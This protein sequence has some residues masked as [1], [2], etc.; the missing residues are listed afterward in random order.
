MRPIKLTLSAFG[1]YAGKEVL[2]LSELGE[3]GLYLVTGKTGAG[4]TSLFDAIAYALYDKPSGDVRDDSMLR[5]TYADDSTE[6]FVEL[7][8]L[9][10]E[11]LYRVRRNPEY[12]RLKARGEGKTKQSARAELIL[13]DGRVIDKSKKEVTRAITEIIGIDREQFLQIAMI[14]QGEF[15]KVLLAD[16]EER[17][18]I[19]RQ[20][21][22][23]ERY[24]TLQN[25]L[26]E[27]TLALKRE[28]D[29]VR[30]T[31]Y[32][33]ARNVRYAEDGK[34]VEQA[35]KAKFGELTV[36]ETTELLQNLIA[37]DEAKNAAVAQS[38][39]VAEKRLE[40]L[41]AV[42]ARAEEKEKAVA[43]RDRKKAELPL[44]E[45]QFKLAKS[46]ADKL[47]AAKPE[48]EEK[49]KLIAL[50]E[51]ETVNYDVAEKL[52]SELKE[53]D[54]YIAQGKAAQIAAKESVQK[55]EQE[56]ADLKE[57]QKSL[58]EV[59]IK[60]AECEALSERLKQEKQKLQDLAKNVA[61]LK[62][63]NAELAAKRREY[64]A[65]SN[66]AKSL[67]DEYNA[68]YKSFLDGQ[69]GIIASTLNEGEPCPVCGSLT[70]PR[71]ACNRDAVPTEQELNRLKKR[72]E[73]EAKNAEI[74]SAEC[75]KT[76]G[77]VETLEKTVKEQAVTLLGEEQNVPV[78]EAVRI[79]FSAVAKRLSEV[80]AEFELRLQ[81]VKRKEKIDKDLPEE[82]RLL[83][84]LRARVTAIENKIAA[85]GATQKE[86]CVQANE[87]SKK[88]RYPSKVQAIAA[89]TKLSAEVRA[90]N[91]ECERAEADVNAKREKALDLRSKISAL[92]N[93]ISSS[94]TVDLA[95]ERTK[96]AE[97]VA[98][99]QALQ[100]EKESVVSRI[101]A[102]K[103]C[104]DGVKNAAE[105]SSA[106]EKRYGW[107]YAL[108]ATACGGI[109]D[110]EKISFETY[111]QTSYFERILH[112][113]NIR[114]QK[115][116]GGQY[117]LVRRVDELGKR[118]QV[119]LDIDVLDHY[120]GTIRPVNS[121]SGGEQFKASLA[122]ALGL[123]DEIR[124]SAG[125]VRLDT[126]FVDEGFGSLDGESLNLAIS[127]LQE[128]TEGNR[129]VGIISHV[130]ELKNKIDKQ[131]VVEKNGIA[132]RGCHARIVLP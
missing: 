7:E 108:Y 26:K 75:A 15:R 41:N 88:L 11:K 94:V 53:I 36:A 90:Y 99:K 124:S 12:T 20:L 63:I 58:A 119:G 101:D 50:L 102:N 19:F 84:G 69:A 14:A 81:E 10:K 34:F 82:E 79:K 131:I 3:N 83:E 115:M 121:L 4:K 76:H 1:P 122:L 129:L 107:M 60:K 54:E 51:S 29:G 16:T 127:T 57:K 23:T 30:Q 5:S 52:R 87:L 37:E 118:S 21:F 62:D 112:R 110:K 104:L 111:V 103:N 97:I 65:A 96:K 27:E 117:D 105:E 132:N 39:S 89:L 72:A 106:L 71:L 80:T 109:A 17:K 128:L 86:K 25:R 66:A 100:T 22:K 6:T 93:F 64:V 61:E 49:K 73:E 31:L 126:M 59:G 78:E 123:S 120:N 42:V 48:I 91:V 74:K 28:Y 95:M 98:S 40:E 38:L 114:L 46:V 35:Q 43:E 47:V 55:K 8:F 18:K 45:E 113:A 70:H 130:E 125:S 32:S 56:L 13:P 44:A 116:T 24:E 92:E 77:K 68:L 33:Y 9:C 2:N 67:A 85:A